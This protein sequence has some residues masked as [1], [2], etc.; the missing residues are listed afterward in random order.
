MAVKIPPHAKA[1]VFGGRLIVGSLAIPV[2]IRVFGTRVP[3]E[4]LRIV[5]GYWLNFEHYHGAKPGTPEFERLDREYLRLLRRMRQNMMY[6]SGIKVTEPGDGKY[7]FDF[8]GMERRIERGLEAGMTMFSGPSLG[9]RKS[10]NES[11]ILLNGKIPA[12]SFEGYRYLSQFL[13]ALRNMLKRR[14]WLDRFII[15]VA[16]EPNDKNATEYRAL[17][18]LIR[19]FVP[20]IKLIDAMS[21][22]ELFGSVDIWV[23]LNS[24]YQRHQKEFDALREM[25]GEIWHYVCCGPRGRYINRFMNFALLCTRYLFWGNYKYNLTG[26][27]HWAKNAFQSG[28]SAYGGGEYRQ[29]P[30]VQ[31]CPEHHNT[32]SVCFLPPGDT[33]LLYPG[34]YNGN[35][36]RQEPWLSMRAENQRMSAEKYEFLRLL[37]CHDKPLADQICGEVFRAF[38]D[39]EFDVKK[40]NDARFSLLAACERLGI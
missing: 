7:E 14:G 22:G 24:E 6:V 19:R 35:G 37:S 8:S 38:D 40:F 36:E 27:L 3:D 21:Y 9:L 12:M 39:V 20:D 2:R 23:P 5:Q 17:C 31:S 15:G 32:D 11:T 16:D 28:L 18:G 29:D 1:G 10:W 25:G 13:P 26:Y 4:S 34:G 33:H 30:F